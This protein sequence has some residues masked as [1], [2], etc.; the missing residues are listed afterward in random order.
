[1]PS[2]R[3]VNLLKQPTQHLRMRTLLEKFKISII[4][5][6]SHVIEE[7]L[8]IV[9]YFFFSLM[10]FFFFLPFSPKI[11]LGENYKTFTVQCLQ[12]QFVVNWFPK[13]Y[14]N[15]S[16]LILLHS[17]SYF[18]QSSPEYIHSA[19]TVPTYKLKLLLIHPLSR[20]AFLP[21]YTRKKKKKKRYKFW[22]FL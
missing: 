17:K 4:L 5:L 3:G 20:K 18:C 2:V 10:L 11:L 15:S 14:Y 9:K 22:N 1:M 7:Y 19:P 21:F 16:W 6:L 12:S 13:I 8:E